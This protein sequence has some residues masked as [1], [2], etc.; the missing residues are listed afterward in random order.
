MSKPKRRKIMFCFHKWKIKEVVYHPPVKVDSVD[1]VSEHF[2][3]IVLNGVSNIHLQ[4]EKCGDIKTQEEYG[5]ARS[6]MEKK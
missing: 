1:N 2:A 4:C 3:R 6:L 5:D